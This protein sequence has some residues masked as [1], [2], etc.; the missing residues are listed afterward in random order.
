MIHALRFD[1]A[2]QLIME[3]NYKS[4]EVNPSSPFYGLTRPST[5][6]VMR[7]TIEP[8]NDRS[9]EKTCSFFPERFSSR[10]E[11]AVFHDE[12]MTAMH[13]TEPTEAGDQAI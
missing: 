6:F 12:N 11:C 3:Q 9:L 8:H 7:G 13:R 2:L 4:Q 1:C 10:I 5:V